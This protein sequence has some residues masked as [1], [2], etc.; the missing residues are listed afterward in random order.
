MVHM[1]QGQGSGKDVYLTSFVGQRQRSSRAVN[2]I[3][4]A[5]T[6]ITYTVQVAPF[7]SGTTAS[8]CTGDRFHTAFLLKDKNVFVSCLYCL[9]CCV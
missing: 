2:D 9:V 4:S 5:A 7:S 1:V 6:T 3:D 8:T